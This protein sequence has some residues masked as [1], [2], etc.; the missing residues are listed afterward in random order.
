MFEALLF[1]CNGVIQVGSD[2]LYTGDMWSS[3]P[4]GLKSHDLQY[5][6]PPLGWDDTT[7]PPTIRPMT[8]VSNFTISVR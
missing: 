7:Q 3:A 8:F 5:W 6:S 1:Q 4:D 2:F